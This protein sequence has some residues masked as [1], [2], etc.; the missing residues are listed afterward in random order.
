MI[1]TLTQWDLVEKEEIS[2]GAAPIGP[3]ELGR[4][5][6]YVFALPARYNYAF[7]TG[8]EEVDEIIQDGAFEI[9][10]GE[11]HLDN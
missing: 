8:F 5:E 10:D 6:E 2:L 3:S 7:I 11:S 1:F 9:I 4:N